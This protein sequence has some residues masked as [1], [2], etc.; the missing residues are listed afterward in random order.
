MPATVPTISSDHKFAGISLGVA[1]IYSP[2][3]AENQISG[4]H[5]ALADCA[6]DGYG[7]SRWVG[8]SMGHVYGSTDFFSQS[9]DTA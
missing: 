9:S 8:Y 4:R 3:D 2:K 5:L 7:D 1:G 6:Q